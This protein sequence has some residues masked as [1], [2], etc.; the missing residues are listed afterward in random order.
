MLCVGIT[1]PIG[2]G[3][4]TVAKL[5]ATLG[6]EVMD[7]DQISKQLCAPDQPALKKIIAHFGPE[8]LDDHGAL[9]RRLLRDKIF[10]HPA[11]RKW[12]EQL[13][14]PLIRQKITATLQ[15]PT[16]C[17][18]MIEIPLLNDKRLYPYLN[19]TLV[20]LANPENRKKRVMERDNQNHQQVNAIVKTQADD[21][22]YHNLGDDLI[23]NNGSLK[24]LTDA[25]HLLHMKF[26]NLSL[27]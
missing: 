14:H 27:K 19:R 21:A 6:A 17:Y 13:L 20:V 2:C 7:A 1:G 16:K 4:S 5:F 11:E 22:F 15:K 10:S 26:I 18:Y 24:E 3:K 25:V 23:I 12:L 8:Y 9:K